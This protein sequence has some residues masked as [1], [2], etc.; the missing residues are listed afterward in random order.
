M[1]SWPSFM[2]TPWK[3]WD[4]M[5]FTL[6]LVIRTGRAIVPSLVWRHLDSIQ[7]AGTLPPQEAKHELSAHPGH[8]L[9]PTSL[10]KGH[11]AHVLPLG[12]V[13]K[14]QTGMLG[15]FWSTRGHLE[16]HTFP[17]VMGRGLTNSTLPSPL[18]F[19]HALCTQPCCL[20]SCHIQS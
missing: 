8:V 3:C 10:L 5:G 17:P 20:H 18:T 1:D 2:L 4:S 15:L 14:K 6:L 11:Q 16:S 12:G 7:P 19:I 13:D 9:R